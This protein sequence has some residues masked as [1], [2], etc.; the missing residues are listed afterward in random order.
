MKLKNI[1]KKVSLPTAVA[2]VITLTATSCGTTAEQ[3]GSIGG[4]SI[5]F[6][7]RERQIL[8]QARGIGTVLGAAAGYAIAKNNGGSRLGGALA[9]ASIGGLLGN[10][11]GTNQA[12]KARNSRLTNTQLRTLLAR[13]K[14]NNRQIAAANRRAKQR[15]AAARAASAS[16]RSKM[17]RSGRLK[18][19]RDIAQ[20]DS[21]IKKRKAAAVKLHGSQRSQYLAVNREAERERAALL[22]SRN[23]LAGME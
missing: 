5:K 6:D 12:N 20:V 22:R 11:V 2:L 7:S 10:A 8:G 18:A 1:I 4:G 14:E 19:D 17:A 16:D 9:G 23:T 3:L 15:I 13:A 21:F